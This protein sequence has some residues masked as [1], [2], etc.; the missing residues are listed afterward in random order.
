VSN[1]EQRKPIERP[2][3]NLVNKLGVRS[4]VTKLVSA[5]RKYQ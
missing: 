1:L 4:F 2:L 5:N 3:N